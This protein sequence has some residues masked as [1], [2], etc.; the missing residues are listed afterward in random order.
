MIYTAQRI[1]SGDKGGRLHSSGS[2]FPLH[3]SLPLRLL[4]NGKIAFGVVAGEEEGSSK[5][6][7]VT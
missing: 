3:D 7:T 1:K 5:K 4:Q 2:K 6:G